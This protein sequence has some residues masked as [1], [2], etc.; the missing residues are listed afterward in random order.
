MSGELRLDV[1]YDDHSRVETADSVNRSFAW[2]E[3]NYGSLLL[4][5]LGVLVE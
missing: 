2:I 3:L 1:L 4:A 5:A